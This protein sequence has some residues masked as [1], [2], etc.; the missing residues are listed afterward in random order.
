MAAALEDFICPTKLI[1][2][3]QEIRL[4]PAF[5]LRY[6]HPPLLKHHVL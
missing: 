5:I 6:F 3:V 2:I 1:V 4:L